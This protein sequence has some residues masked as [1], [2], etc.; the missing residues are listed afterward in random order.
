VEA[1]RGS[2]WRKRP[3]ARFGHNHLTRAG[4]EFAQPA[5]AVLTAVI[6]DRGRGSRTACSASAAHEL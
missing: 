6:G 5:A 3:G 2:E 4:A 1:G